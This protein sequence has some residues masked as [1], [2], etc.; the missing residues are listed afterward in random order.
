MEYKRGESPFYLLLILF[1]KNLI[2]SNLRYIYF[3]IIVV[4]CTYK[5]I[6]DLLDWRTRY[7]KY[8]KLKKTTY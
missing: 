6:K 3:P 8:I 7:G 1:Y 4:L 2:C 5:Q